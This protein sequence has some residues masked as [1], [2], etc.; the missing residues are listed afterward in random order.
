MN[1]AA[2][3]RAE[4]LVEGRDQPAGGDILRRARQG[5]GLRRMRSKHARLTNGLVRTAVDELRRPVGG[6]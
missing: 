4:R 3:Q 2:V 6:Q 1:A 5:Q